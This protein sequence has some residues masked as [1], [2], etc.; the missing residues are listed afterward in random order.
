MTRTGAGTAIPS[1]E[2]AQFSSRRQKRKTSR[3]CESGYAGHRVG[4]QQADGEY[5]PV[6][7]VAAPRHQ[8][9]T[10][11]VAIT[12]PIV[13]TTPPRKIEFLHGGFAVPVGLGWQVPCVCPGFEEKP[14]ERRCKTGTVFFRCWRHESTRPGHAHHRGRR[15]EKLAARRRGST[16]VVRSHDDPPHRTS[17]WKKPGSPQRR[18]CR[19][20]PPTVR[21]LARRRGLPPLPAGFGR[22]SLH[23][24]RWPAH[25]HLSLS[26]TRRR[27]PLARY[28]RA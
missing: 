6:M 21:R 19:A 22:V 1:G 9:E 25:Y 15:K 5:P 3:V 27:D 7:S 12:A 24:R 2:P 23:H 13:A 18:T 28:P 16:K 17:K 10:E 26:G 8:G 20:R 14:G 4:G 11:N